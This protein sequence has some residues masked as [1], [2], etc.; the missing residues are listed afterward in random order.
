MSGHESSRPSQVSVT[1][2]AAV[3]RAT[4]GTVSQY[5]AH[6]FS[7]SWCLSRASPRRRRLQSCANHSVQ[8]RAGIACIMAI[9]CRYSESPMRIV[10]ALHCSLFFWVAKRL[11]HCRR[12]AAQPPYGPP[13][14]LHCRIGIG[15]RPRCFAAS[16]KGGLV[17]ATSPLFQ[18]G[19]DCASVAICCSHCRFIAVYCSCFL[20]AC[21]TFFAAVLCLLPLD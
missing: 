16:W 6:T 12:I 15:S 8:W 9:A 2:T 3:A 5:S 10:A 20:L 19:L 17:P 14:L 4:P 21:C 11:Q 7:S 18:G 13:A 1:V